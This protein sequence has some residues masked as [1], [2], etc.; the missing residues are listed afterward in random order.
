MS[1]LKKSRLKLYKKYIEDITLEISQS[2]YWRELLF[3]NDYNKK[4]LISSESQHEIPNYIKPLIF[5]FKLQFYVS[6]VLEYPE[7]FDE[8]S[9]IFMFEAL[10][11]PSV[12]RYSGN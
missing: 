10:E 3:N 1:E 12:V 8:G 11:F 9:I 4:F 6:K 5:N 7:E 2:N